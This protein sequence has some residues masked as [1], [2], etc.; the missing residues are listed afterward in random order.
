MLV[1]EDNGHPFAESDD[2]GQEE[3]NANRGNFAAKQNQRSPRNIQIEDMNQ[4]CV[5]PR[6]CSLGSN[7]MLEVIPTARGLRTTPRKLRARKTFWLDLLGRPSGPILDSSPA[8]I[9]LS[10]SG[11]RS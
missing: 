3:G 9:T 11:R 10:Y 5:P 6:R 7:C 2:H 8:Q 4:S 1:P